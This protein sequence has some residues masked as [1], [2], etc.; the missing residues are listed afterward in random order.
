MPRAVR[1]NVLIEWQNEL[2]HQYYAHNWWKWAKPMCTREF[3]QVMLEQKKKS[4]NEF[5]LIFLVINGLSAS[6]FS[7]NFS[8]GTTLLGQSVI[9][10]RIYR[11]QIKNENDV[12]KFALSLSLVTLF[13][14]IEFRIPNLNYKL[15]FRSL[16]HCYHFHLISKYFLCVFFVFILHN[17]FFRPPRSLFSRLLDEQQSIKSL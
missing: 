15:V 9:V 4:M 7:F 10:R 16:P 8:N 14:H 6:G 12:E 1:M 2:T 13:H 17:F 11:L 3:V 5:V